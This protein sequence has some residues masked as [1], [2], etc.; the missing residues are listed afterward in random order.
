MNDNFI[1][2][3]QDDWRAQEHDISTVVHRLRA[4]RWLPHVVLGAEIVSCAFAFLVGIWFAWVAVH[5]NEHTLLFALSAGIMLIAA[6]ALLVA[7]VIARHRSLAWHTETPASLLSV[8]IRRAE[9]SLSAIRIGRWHVAIIGAFVATL[10]VLQMIGLISAM[11]FLI[12]Y[13][14]VCAM[15]SITG[16]LWM[17]R[18]EK[19]VR[20]E[21]AA[22]VRLLADLEV[23]S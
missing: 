1:R 12:F 16:W 15:V 20:S 21:R 5:T 22:M 13:T 23:D 17:A 6:P 19:R 18:R 9:S 14:T 11:R 7:S 3:L 4:T 8:G 10:W 2:S